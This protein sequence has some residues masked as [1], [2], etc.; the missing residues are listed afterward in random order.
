VVEFKRLWD[1][2]F[3]N[4]EMKKFSNE[5]IDAILKSQIHEEVQNIGMLDLS[6]DLATDTASLSKELN[7]AVIIRKVLFRN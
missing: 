3:P 1:S 4:A 5:E 6:S 7:N 2:Q